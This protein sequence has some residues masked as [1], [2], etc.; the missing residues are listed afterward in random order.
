MKKKNEHNN[1]IRKLL[2]LPEVNLLIK[3]SKLV[4]SEEYE[5]IRKK[6]E[7]NKKL[8]EPIRNSIANEDVQLMFKQIDASKSLSDLEKLELIIS[9]RSL[10]A[11]LIPTSKKVIDNF[12]KVFGKDFSDTLLGVNYKEVAKPEPAQ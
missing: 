8:F 3:Y 12:G 5:K 7:L 11:G 1:A 4:K 6:S 2:N 10:L 9:F